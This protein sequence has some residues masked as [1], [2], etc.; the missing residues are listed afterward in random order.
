MHVLRIYERTVGLWLE[1]EGFSDFV[2][3]ANSDPVACWAME[4]RGLGRRD[5]EGS[6]SKQEAV[7]IKVCV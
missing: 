3:L 6:L 4:N 5:R 1:S 7:C 2:L